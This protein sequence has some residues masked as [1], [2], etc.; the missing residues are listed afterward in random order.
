[1]YK[2]KNN[3]I[4]Q[5]LRKQMSNQIHYDYRLHVSPM[6]TVGIKSMSPSNKMTHNQIKTKTNLYQIKQLSH[7]VKKQTPL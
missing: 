6:T 1:M 5:S 4:I 3:P 2:M 7:T